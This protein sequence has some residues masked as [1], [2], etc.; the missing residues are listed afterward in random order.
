MPSKLSSQHLSI[1]IASFSS[2][3][4]LQRCL[5]SLQ[6]NVKN[7]EI[8]VSTCFAEDDVQFLQ[9][10]YE[11][12]FIFNPDEQKL[13]SVRLRETRVFRLRSSGVKAANGDIIL[14]LE[15]H[16][17]VTPGWLDSMLTALSDPQCIAGGP[18][19]NGASNSLF[20]WALY[21]SEYAAMMPPFPDAEVQYLSAV[22]SGYFKTALQDCREVWQQGFYD[23]EVHDALMKRGAKLCLAKEAIVETR[24]PFTF[25]Q[26]FVHLFTGGQRYGGYR[27][28]RRWN[29]QRIIRL[30]ATTVVPAVLFMRVFNFVRLRRPSDLLTFAFAFPV[31]YILLSAW[32]AGELVGTLRG[33]SES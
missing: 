14:M 20:Y 3:Q 33:D 21:W 26:A 12:S 1:V 27:G 31:L 10:Q 15:D 2:V 5:L 9:Q 13:D 28:G 17:E 11:V 6:Q 25:S 29:M 4:H 8:I 23:N 16:C 30:F 24:L 19:A 32:G 22:N 18:I 7:A